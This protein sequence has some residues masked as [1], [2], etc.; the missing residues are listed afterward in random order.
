MAGLAVG[1]RGQNPSHTPNR[2]TGLW[3]GR[4]ETEEATARFE[5]KKR[6]T[7]YSGRW[8]ISYREPL[9]GG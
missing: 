5:E 9:L 8:A 7:M 3:G 2:V 6:E 4:A 1:P